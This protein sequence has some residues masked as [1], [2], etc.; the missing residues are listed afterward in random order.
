MN[1]KLMFSCH[2]YGMKCTCTCTICTIWTMGM[3]WKWNRRKV[4]QQSSI[5]YCSVTMH[6]VATIY[7]ANCCVECFNVDKLSNLFLPYLENNCA[8]TNWP[9]WF[10]AHTWI[11]L[12]CGISKTVDVTHKRYF[13]SSLFYFLNIYVLVC[14]ICFNHKNIIF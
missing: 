1:E 12:T 11:L 13:C 10:I 8:L 7:T 9:V 5:L 14:I 2:G 6:K 3:K 4:L